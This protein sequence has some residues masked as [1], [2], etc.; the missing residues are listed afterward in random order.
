MNKKQ[1]QESIMAGVKKAFKENKSLNEGFSAWSEQNVP[2]VDYNKV[3]DAINSLS[4]L[5]GKL[6]DLKQLIGV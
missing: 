3:N 4:P 6:C 1:L 5:F 2:R